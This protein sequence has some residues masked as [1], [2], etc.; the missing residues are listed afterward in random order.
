M[1]AVKFHD[2]VVDIMSMEQRRVVIGMPKDLP[3]AGELPAHCFFS[4]SEKLS[5]GLPIIAD[6][7]LARS[8]VYPQLFDLEFSRKKPRDAL[9]DTVRALQVLFDLQN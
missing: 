5:G 7:D 3:I 4:L 6:V 8:L 2:V 9:F 1:R